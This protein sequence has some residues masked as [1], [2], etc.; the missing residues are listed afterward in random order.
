MRGHIRYRYDSHRMTSSRLGSTTMAG[1]SVRGV[2]SATTRSTS[3]SPPTLGGAE[4]SPGTRSVDGRCPAARIGRGAT[5]GSAWSLLPVGLPADV[6][7]SAA[8]ICRSSSARST[9]DAAS[10]PDDPASRTVLGPSAA[11]NDHAVLEHPHH[12][13]GEPH[14]DADPYVRPRVLGCAHH[15]AA[16]RVRPRSGPSNRGPRRGP[17]TRAVQCAC[18]AGLAFVGRCPRTSSS[19]PGP[20]RDP[21]RLV[22]A[23]E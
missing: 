18:G 17:R 7:A 16:R 21:T 20:A 23:G 1:G 10:R 8:T 11:P 2:V 22:R 5:V 14:A 6:P 15:R 9:T 19:P 4:T 12:R 13:E 3:S